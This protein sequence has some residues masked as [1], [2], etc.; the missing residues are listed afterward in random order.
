M[1]PAW[2][3]HVVQG[4]S[5]RLLLWTQQE[6][7]R[8]CCVPGPQCCRAAVRGYCQLAGAPACRTQGPLGPQLLAYGCRPLVLA[9]CALQS[10]STSAHLQQDLSPPD[11]FSVCT[12]NTG[13]TCCL[14]AATSPHCSSVNGSPA[15][16]P[17]GAPT[18][19]GSHRPDPSVLGRS[20]ANA[21]AEADRW[22]SAL[23]AP[24]GSWHTHNQQK[25]EEGPQVPS[26]QGGVHRHALG[27]GAIRRSN[28]SACRKAAKWKASLFRSC[29]R[30]HLP[31]SA[32]LC[33]HAIASNTTC[34][35]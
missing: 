9:W 16:C 3:G 30:M 1:A 22:W 5:T 23:Q 17:C 27:V 2:L 29:T 24:G 6:C 25:E 20:G 12:A 4:T 33:G 11:C 19:T 14:L 34:S 8:L 28:A 10:S 7:S 18:P 26:T 31:A 13:V 21:G 32:Q 15:G 35:L